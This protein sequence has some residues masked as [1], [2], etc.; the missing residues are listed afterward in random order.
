MVCGFSSREIARA[1]LSSDTAISQR[2]A[3]AKLRL[4]QV[5]TR[6]EIPALTALTPRLE[7]VLEVLYLLFNEGYS[8]LE[9]DE[10]VRTDFCHEAMRLCQLLTEHTLTNRPEVH[11]LVALFLFQAARLPARADASG[12]LLLL[13]EQD[14]SSWDQALITRG[15]EHL[16]QAASGHCV[17]DVHIEAEIAAH[18]TLSDDFAATDWPRILDC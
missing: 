10:L 5:N 13:Q 9:G 4:R 11:A 16:R 3:R 17:T 2:I 18:H 6:L 1:F 8:A 12:E 15:V 14:R 7:P